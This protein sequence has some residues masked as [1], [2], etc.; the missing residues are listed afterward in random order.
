M[1]RLLIELFEVKA[2][3]I[4]EKI[5]AGIDFAHIEILQLEGF[6]FS[7]LLVT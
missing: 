1:L 4:F 5:V 7:K 6:K 2:A 3:H